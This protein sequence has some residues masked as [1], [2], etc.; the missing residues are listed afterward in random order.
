MY[1]ENAWKKYKDDLSPVMLFAEGYKKFISIGKTERLATKEAEALL[2]QA[3][4]KPVDEFKSFIWRS[5]LFSF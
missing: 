5:G 2:M 1:R 4:F 3:G